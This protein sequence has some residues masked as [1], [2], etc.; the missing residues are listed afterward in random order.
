MRKTTLTLKVL[1]GFSIAMLAVAQEN[2]TVQSSQPSQGD[3]ATSSVSY[4]P[5]QVRVLGDVEYG[6]RKIAASFSSG[7]RYRAFVFSGY[8]G[9]QVEITVKGA[10]GPVRLALADSTLNQVATGSSQ[11]CVSLPYKGPDV[12]LWYIITDNAPTHLVFQVKKIGHQNPTFQQ[13]ALQ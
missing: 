2:T 8:G 4:S 12:E 3:S 11:L 7:P 6:E 10:A 13:A 9:D 5:K 1:L